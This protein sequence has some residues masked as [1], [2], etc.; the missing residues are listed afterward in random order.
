MHW[1]W[2]IQVL[3]A[4]GVLVPALGL[5]GWRA[6]RRRRQLLTAWLGARPEFWPAGSC[7]A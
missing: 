4:A 5:L 2:P 3:L 7:L 1:V 6:A